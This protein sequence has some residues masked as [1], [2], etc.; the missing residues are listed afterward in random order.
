MSFY[1]FTDEDIIDTHIST[2]PVFSVEL[3]GDQV[4]GSVFLEKPYLEN[5][6]ETRIYSLRTDTVDILSDTEQ[7][8]APFTSSIDLATAVSGGTNDGMYCAIRQL[9]RYY[10]AYNFAYSFL[11]AS[12]VRVVTIPEVYYDR[13]ILTGSFTASDNDAAGATRV[14]YDNGRGGLY[15]GSLSASIVGHI[16]YPEGIAILTASNLSNFGSPSTNFKWRVSLKGTHK[17]PVKIFRCR[18]PAGQ[19]NASTNPTYYHIPSG[20]NDANRYQHEI[21]VTPPVTY[22]TTIG[23]YNQHYELVG[24]A[25]LAQPIKKEEAQDI[26]FRVRLDF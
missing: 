12:T 9:Y 17:I 2:Y 7:K 6:L 22:I 16:F 23:L 13:E 11:S 15:S 1:K 26:L 21:M 3:N 10:S 14:L 19:L 20:A 5:S 25:K 4:T 24:T 18:A 8:S